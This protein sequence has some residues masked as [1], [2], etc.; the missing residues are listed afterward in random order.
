[1]I[2]RLRALAR[3]FRAAPLTPEQADLIQRI[4]FP[5]C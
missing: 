3:R 4:R 1:V 5:C 2:A